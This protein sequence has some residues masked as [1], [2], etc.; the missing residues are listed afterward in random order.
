[1][2]QVKLKHRTGADTTCK[3][4]FNNLIYG[5]DTLGTET[6][7]EEFQVSNTTFKTL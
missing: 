7:N 5:E 3:G 4:M 1:V 6:N 2:Y